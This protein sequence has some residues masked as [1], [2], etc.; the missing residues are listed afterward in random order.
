MPTVTTEAEI[1]G[2]MAESLRS[3]AEDCK[4]LAWNSRR[5]FVYDRFRKDL[6]L[7]EGCCR[8]I[9]YWRDYDSRWLILK[10]LCAFAHERAG[11]WLRNSPTREMRNKAHPVFQK[12]SEQLEHM[13]RDVERLRHMATGRRG[14]ILPDELPEPDVRSGRPVQV[15]LPG[16]F[17]QRE[18]GLILPLG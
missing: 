17:T 6:K 7:I 8:Q 5:G 11:T 18:S 14:P 10:Q 4:Q 16:G 12:L 9:Y 15:N 1:F 3:A 13:H 2:R